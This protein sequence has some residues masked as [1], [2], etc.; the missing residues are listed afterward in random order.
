MA[1]NLLKYSNISYEEIVQQ[2]IEKMVADP[3]FDNVRE[4]DIGLMINEIFGGVSEFL[5]HYLERRT[6]ESWLD[7]SKLRGSGIVNARSLGYSVQRAIPAQCKLSITLKGNLANIVTAVGNVIQIPQ[8]SPFSYRGYNYI[9]KN[10]V[11]LLITQ[12]IYNSIQADG[13]NFSYTFTTDS[14]GEDIKLIE[15]TLKNQIIDGSL[16]VLCGQKFQTYRISDA[17]FSN[18][19]GDNDFDVPVTRVWVGSE[20]SDENEYQIDCRS[21]INNKTIQAITNG[22][23]LNMC[24]IRSAIDEGIE[25]L[26]GDASFASLGAE[27]STTVAGT[28][29]QTTYDNIYIQYL[30]TIGAKGNKAGFIGESL[31]YNGTASSILINNLSNIDS[32]YFTFS[33]LS[34]PIGGA[35][36]ESLD[37]IKINAPS[38]YYSL[39]RLV[40]AKDYVNYLRTLTS[41]IQI[42]NALAWGEQEE[43]LKQGLTY[44]PKMFNV[45]LFSCIGSLYQTDTSPYDVISTSAI[46]DVVLDDNYDPDS[47]PMQSYFNIY[48]SQNQ[49]GQLSA[50]QTSAVSQNILDVIEDL[51]SRSEITVN[52]VYV[53]PI[54]QEFSL[55]GTV[56]VN[57]LFDRSSIQTEIYN[58]IYDYL[59]IN[60]DFNTPIYLSNLVELIEK[61]NGVKYTDVEFIPE[62]PSGTFFTAGTIEPYTSA[63]NISLDPE[64]IKG[65]IAATVINDSTLLT[66]REFFKAVKQYIDE[67]GLFSEEFLRSSDFLSILGLLR[68]DYLANIRTNLINPSGD[69]GERVLVNNK[70]LYGY[71]LGT[72]IPRVTCKL[73]FEYKN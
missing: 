1:N 64:I 11:S 67:S 73:N 51:N 28:G 45:A 55:S 23:V 16:N 71:S 26:F 24:V 63:W 14:S 61:V 17:T 54:I 21:L 2:I 39:E 22:D 66:E 43:I 34:N 27:I 40:T 37:S 33:F 35:D 58:S 42:K 50:Y 60:A 9:L 65:S 38:I 6:E 25:L 32:S 69:I 57:P 48:V 7:T 53:S 18:C 19:Y 15:G 10:T 20:K 52:N 5:L 70:Y 68:K 8:Y 56:Y 59:N 72:E 31:I 30:S 62:Y 41:P 49:L 46:S 12:E 4:S 47:I 36:M 13:S 29:A 3:R 44:D